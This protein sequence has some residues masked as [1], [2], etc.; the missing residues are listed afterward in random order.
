[1]H[2]LLDINMESKLLMRVI[3]N[4]I[5]SIL[6]ICPFSIAGLYAYDNCLFQNLEFEYSNEIAANDYEYSRNP[7]F[8]NRG[9]ERGYNLYAVYGALLQNHYRRR[10]DPTMNRLYGVSFFSNKLLDE[11]STLAT[12]VVFD[13]SKHYDMYGSLEKD[14]YEHYFSFTDSTTG[15]TVYYGPRLWVLYKRTIAPRLGTALQIEYGIE[16]GLKDVYTEC[17]TIFRNLDV[18]LG[19]GYRS[20]GGSFVCG[21]YGRVFDRQGK[22]EAV[23]GLLEAVNFSYIG[24]QV[25]RPEI[26]RDANHKSDRKTGYEMGVYVQKE[27]LFIPGL[28]WR[29]ALLAGS[30]A[31]T[32]KTGSRSQ[33]VP[34]GYWV[35][36]A[37]RMENRLSYRLETL[38]CELGLI[39]DVGKTVDWAQHGQFEVNLL[40][41]R[42]TDRL[43]GVDVILGPWRYFSLRTG[44]RIGF[45]DVDYHE[46]TAAFDFSDN[47]KTSR[48]FVDFAVRFNKI[49]TL[50]LG[51][52]NCIEE[53]FFYWNTP[54]FD[55]TGVY[56][57]WYRQFVVGQIGLRIDAGVWDP[58]VSNNRIEYCRVSLSLKN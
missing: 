55:I 22:Y 14:F 52:E 2:P 56:L 15:N 47:L 20:V 38:R 24:Y 49:T 12:A 45:R 30:T 16:R 48:V 44:Y 46:Y 29:S 42:D 54:E 18:K 3:V 27:A 39:Y 58:S 4:I 33:P 10:F 28:E 23:S 1:M 57:A 8:F 43:M 17:M 19:L 53:P 6:L 9:V 11:K 21:I 36:A 50:R 26:S 32:I 35:R 51:Y 25:Y 31:S 13:R 34:V 5:A 7:A 37:V 41:Y 40:D